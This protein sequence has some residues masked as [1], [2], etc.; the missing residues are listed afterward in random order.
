M[1]VFPYALQWGLVSYTEGLAAACPACG[2]VFT[3]TADLHVPAH[4]AAR[5]KACPGAGRLVEFADGAAAAGPM[6]HPA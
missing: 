3:S 4:E 5:G 2:W 1:S 6:F